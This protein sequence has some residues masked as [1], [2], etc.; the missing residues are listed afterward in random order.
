MNTQTQKKLDA[1][2]WALDQTI[3]IYGNALAKVTAQ[4]D[5]LLAAARIALDRLEAFQPE[6]K[7][8]VTIKTLKLAIE[9]ASKPTLD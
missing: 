2:D 3:E 1:K 9:N 5:E 7:T 6:I 4:R 8:P